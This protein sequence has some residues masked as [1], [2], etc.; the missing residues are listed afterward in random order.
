VV[1]NE[2]ENKV[3]RLMSR[4]R[5]YAKTNYINISVV[6][7]VTV[8]KNKYRE[9]ICRYRIAMWDLMKYKTDSHEECVRGQS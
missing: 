4:G 5:F 9:R 8:C 7:R 3:T 2:R 6:P 1:F